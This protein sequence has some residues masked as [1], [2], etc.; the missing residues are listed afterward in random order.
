MDIQ[1]LCN[2]DDDI[3][4][5]NIGGNSRKHRSWIKML[6]AHDGHAVLVGGGP[7]LQEHLPTIKKRKDL[8]QTIFALN[9]AAK[10]LNDNGIIP[11]YQVILDARPDNVTLL[12]TARKELPDRLSVRPVR[13]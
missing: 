1:I 6:E 9:G 5:A 4:F 3:L 7:S 2:T 8:G 11:E 12:G 10:F 13:F